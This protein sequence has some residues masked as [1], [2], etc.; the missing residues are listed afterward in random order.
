MKIS[1]SS[2]KPFSIKTISELEALDQNLPNL[3]IRNFRQKCSKQKLFILT[4]TKLCIW[5]FFSI[6]KNKVFFKCL[7]SSKNFL[8]IEYTQ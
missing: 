7:N 5:T 3:F 2:I 8:K 6:Y 4:S 1:I